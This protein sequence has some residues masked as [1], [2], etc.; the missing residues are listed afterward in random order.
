MDD[1]SIWCTW[2]Y[3]YSEVLAVFSFRYFSDIIDLYVIFNIKEQ[4]Y[5]HEHFQHS[6]HTYT[7][8]PTHTLSLRTQ[9]HYLLVFDGEVVLGQKQKASASASNEVVQQL[10]WMWVKRCKLLHREICVSNPEILAN[11]IISWLWVHTSSARSSSIFTHRIPRSP[12]LLSFTHTHCWLCPQIE[13][14][15]N[16][17]ECAASNKSWV[18]LP[19]NFLAGIL[20]MLLQ[21][22]L[23]ADTT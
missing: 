20:A 5:I 2:P 7:N 19:A 8:T 13:W 14:L 15:Q 17:S 9:R 16:T 21:A 6:T 1:G 4:T 11:P 23:N 10:H 22:R 12:S 18:I 3:N